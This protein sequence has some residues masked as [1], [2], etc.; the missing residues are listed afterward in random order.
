[1]GY[2]IPVPIV[3]RVDGFTVR[4]FL[5]PREHGP[6]HVHVS[7]QGGSVII[8]LGSPAEGVSVRNIQGLRASDV[9]VAV[10]IVQAHIE[11][12]RSEWRKYHE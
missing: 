4:I 8:L 1:M 6:A 12:L 9:M 10:R 2:R 7:K 5:P 3:L 11:D